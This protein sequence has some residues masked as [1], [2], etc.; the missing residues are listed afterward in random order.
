M[1]KKRI[2]ELDEFKAMKAAAAKEANRKHRRLVKEKLAV[3]NTVKDERIDDVLDLLRE[4]KIMLE[5]AEDSDEDTSDEDEDEP[6]QDKSVKTKKKL[7]KLESDSEEED[8][9]PVK[10]KKKV[11]KRVK[12]AVIEPDGEGLQRRNPLLFNYPTYV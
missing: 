4:I 12:T 7:T 1:E 6:R 2:S 3:A 5:V 9:E 8:P 10:K 11:M